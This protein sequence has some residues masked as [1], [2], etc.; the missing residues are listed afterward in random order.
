MKRTLISVLMSFMV[1]SSAAQHKTKDVRIPIIKYNPATY[2]SDI[3]SALAD[4]ASFE[5]LSADSQQLSGE[6]QDILEYVSGQE[7]FIV[8]LE[9]GDT[10]IAPKCIGIKDKEKGS[11]KYLNVED[12]CI[13]HSL[14]V[15]IEDLYGT[16]EDYIATWPEDQKHLFYNDPQGLYTFPNKGFATDVVGWGNSENPKNPVKFKAAISYLR[17]TKPEWNDDTWAADSA[18]IVNF[19]ESVTGI[20][21]E[22]HEEKPR[23]EGQDANHFSK[24]VNE[25]LTYPDEALEDAVTGRVTLQFKIDMFGNLEGLKVLRGRHPALDS[26]ALN[27]VSSSPEWTPAKNRIGD[28][29]SVVY[30]FPVIFTPEMM[31]EAFITKMYNE[32]LYE[33]HDFMQKHCSPELLQKLQDAYPYDY[34]APAYATWLFRSGQQ[35]SKPGSD[36][37]T[38]M[39]DIKADGDWYVYTALDMG[40]KFTNRIKVISKDGKI[41]IEDMDLTGEW[42]KAF[43]RNSYLYHWHKTQNADSTVMAFCELAKHLMPDIQLD[44]SA[45]KAYIMSAEKENA[46]EGEDL[47]NIVTA[48]K[49]Y[50]PLCSCDIYPYMKEQMSEDTLVAFYNVYDSWKTDLK[51]ALRAIKDKCYREISIELYGNDHDIIGNREIVKYLIKTEK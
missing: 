25:R 20:I 8:S 19:S 45:I 41:I 28:P 17:T 29:C 10:E 44:P 40:W 26:I 31:F 3:D 9:D 33:D 38:M 24:W 15:V 14:D 42:A 37:K 23:F 1:L 46:V 4:P 36:G 21:I 48:G 16:L 13:R 5:C 35:D 47:L 27:V 6:I 32:K 43:V 49:Y 22:Y 11:L 30:A 51:T 7:A 12:E 50:T 34:E 39:L 18:E 2:L